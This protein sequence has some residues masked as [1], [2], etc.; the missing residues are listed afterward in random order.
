[1]ASVRII[2][3]GCKANQYDGDALARALARLGYGI[4]TGRDVARQSR[5]GGPKGLAAD[6]YVVNTCAVTVAAQ[7]KGRKLIRR[8]ARLHPGAVVA[9]GC[10]AEV[11]PKSLR[12]IPGV[13]AVIGNSGKPELA[14]AVR[15]LLPTPE[16][17]GA[18]QTINASGHTR[19]IIK[20]QDGCNMACSYCV[21]RL[22]RGPMR[23]RPAAEVL[24]E[25]RALADNGVK[26]IVLTGIRLG[27]YN[28]GGRDLADLVAATDSIVPRIRLS[29]LDVWDLTPP[30]LAAIADN[31]AVCPHLHL[32][33]QSG[34]DAVLRAM[35][36]PYTVREYVR[37]VEMARES[38]PDVALTT[39]VMVGF[40]GESEQAFENTLRLVQD[41]QFADLHVFRYSPRPGTAAA[42]M[43]GAVAEEVKTE[44]SERML[45]LAREL[46]LQ[47]AQGFMGQSVEVLFETYDS[48]A[49]ACEGI[50]RH[51][52]RVVAPGSPEMCN[53][54]ATVRVAEATSGMARGSI[55]DM[56]AQ[57]AAT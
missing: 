2:S 5:Y 22:A 38:I 17:S 13:A 1:M 42:Q 10:A 51:Y 29:S 48:G 50:S 25:I 34:D 18:R 23:S 3:H 44:R 56:P 27:A 4:A 30:L 19:A 31:P 54:L 57:S 46:A 16:P 41:L 26:E 37:R 40:P 36:R 49:G 47:F 6:V 39:D 32:P 35:K 21:V 15:G 28:D 20:V 9:T 7:A 33:L 8:L 11:A 24:D 53:R 43:G 55:D 14:A 45:A 12:A 52:L